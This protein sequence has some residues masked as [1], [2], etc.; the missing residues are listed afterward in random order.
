MNK[1]KKR[2]HIEI[3]R[4]VIKKCLSI[5]KTE[6]NIEENTITFDEENLILNSEI[7]IVSRKLREL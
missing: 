1:R 4:T 3:E 7:N 5:Y 2:K 6:T